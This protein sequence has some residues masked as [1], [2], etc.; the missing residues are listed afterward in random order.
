ME[1][2]L[3][4]KLVEQDTRAWNRTLHGSFDP[5]TDVDRSV[6]R[7]VYTGTELHLRRHGSV[8][9][10]LRFILWGIADAKSKSSN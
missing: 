9:T 3:P 5:L 10:I 1:G 2:G 8:L 6:P 7:A 4:V